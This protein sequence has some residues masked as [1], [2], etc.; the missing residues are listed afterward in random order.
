MCRARLDLQDGSSPG[1]TQRLRSTGAVELRQV[2]DVAGPGLHN[3]EAV[4]PLLGLRSS[5]HTRGTMNQWIS[6]LT[7]E[8]REMLRDYF[9]GAD[10]PDE[11]DPFPELGL[12]VDQTGLLIPMGLSKS[13]VE[14][15]LLSG[16]S[17]YKCCVVATHKHKP[18][19]RRD[20]VWK[21]RLQGRVPVWRLLYKPPLNK[22][23]G[24]LQWRILQGALA[25]NSLVEKSTPRC[26]R[27]VHSVTKLR[28]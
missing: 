20:T 7:S 17:I 13:R 16:K 9:S 12:L 26:P 4:A 27:T 23:T 28:L 3:T 2:V 11:G 22:R 14:L 6:R 19:N 21:E 24:D 5:R 18:S 1:L 10:V 8:E 25:V 15:Q